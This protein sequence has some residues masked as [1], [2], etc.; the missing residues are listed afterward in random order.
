MFYTIGAPEIF[1]QY[2]MLSR[3]VHHDRNGHGA[4]E[5][6]LRARALLNTGLGAR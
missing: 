5:E 6:A 3:D 1:S 4:D 2:A